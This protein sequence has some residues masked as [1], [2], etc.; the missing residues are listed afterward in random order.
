M[1]VDVGDQGNG[2]SPQ[3]LC[4]CPPD[5]GFATV[6]EWH[7][8]GPAAMDPAQRLCAWDVSPV[9]GLRH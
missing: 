5:P 2:K 3:S 4:R 9:L 6:P 7:P 8:L 1:Y